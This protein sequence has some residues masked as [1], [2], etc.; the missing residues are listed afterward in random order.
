MDVTVKLENTEN[1]ITWYCVQVQSLKR[2]IV[3][4]R[5]EK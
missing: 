5:L 2:V 3:L 4:G 1:C